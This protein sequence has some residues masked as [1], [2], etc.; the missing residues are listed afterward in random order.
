MLRVL[1]VLVFVLCCI[2]ITGTVFAQIN[3]IG[4]I[5]ENYYNNQYTFSYFQGTTQTQTSS[6]RVTYST[7][8]LVDPSQPNGG[9][10]Y[11]DDIMAKTRVFV[12]I[13]VGCGG[14]VYTFVGKVKQTSPFLG[15][16]LYNHSGIGVF[17]YGRFN[18]N[19][20]VM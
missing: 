10:Y 19:D 13:T 4:Q 6:Q 1:C 7:W 20:Q 9:T 12:D 15:N 14:F 5:P 8:G 2:A 11:F 17:N 16:R 3:A 18:L